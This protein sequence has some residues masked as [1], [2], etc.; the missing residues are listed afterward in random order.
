MACYHPIHGWRSPGGQV[1]EKRSGAWVGRELTIACGQC[2]GCRLEQARVWAVRM[3]HETETN[4][5]PEYHP[6]A[7]IE[8]SCFL[9]LTLSE[10][11]K[12]YIDKKGKSYAP[13]SLKLDDWQNFA[14]KMRHRVGKFRFFHCGEYGDQ[15][16]RAHYHAII[17]GQD[18]SN[19]R[20]LW[21]RARENNLYRSPTL[22]RMWTEGH[23]WIGSVTW[24]SCAYVARYCTKKITGQ[25]ATE[26]YEGRKPEY[27]T[28]SRHP[29][30]GAAWIA[31]Y[32]ADV[33]PDDQV[34]INGKETRPPAFYDRTLTE[35]ELQEIKEVRITKGKKYASDNTTDRL[36]VKEK[37]KI[38]QIKQLVR[39]L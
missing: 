3:T 10:P 27:A 9:T 7:G 30:I 1:S 34:V 17:W 28:M 14:K 21:K 23:S 15:D 25:A 29:G 20:Y 4:V 32:G 33:Y 24:Q 12:A 31:K 18:F 22:E 26:H 8:N 38:K 11:H 35:R 6:K 2:I 37:V 13:G 16:G 39:T 36:V 19:D 5:Y